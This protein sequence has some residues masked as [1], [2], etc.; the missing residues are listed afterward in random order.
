MAFANINPK[1]GFNITNV[2]ISVPSYS[3]RDDRSETYKVKLVN[4]PSIYKN[5]TINQKGNNILEVIDPSEDTVITLPKIGGTILI[6]GISTTKNLYCK[7]N[8][9]MSDGNYGSYI[10]QDG[11]SIEIIADGNI[12]NN[13]GGPVPND[14]GQNGTYDFEI[15]INMTT[16]NTL[17]FKEIRIDIGNEYDALDKMATRYFKQFYIYAPPQ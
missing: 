10:L 8:L 13:P 7:L 3:G 14:P 17:S 1:T 2:Q 9:K 15:T 16:N 4:S 11:E 6:Q 5:L 12:I